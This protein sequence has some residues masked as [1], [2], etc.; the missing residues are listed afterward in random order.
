MRK[1][2]LLCVLGVGLAA[3]S[4]DTAAAAEVCAELQSHLMALEMADR[5]Q[6]EEQGSAGDPYAIERQRTVV[7]TALAA[8]RCRSAEAKRNNR[9]NRVF[10]GL[11]GNKRPF[12]SGLFREG[13]M[14]GDGFFGND[15]SMGSYRTLC[16]RTCDGYYFPISFSA[17]G[18]ELQRDGNACR[19]LCP[20]QD[21]A[22]YVQRNPGDEGGPMVSLAGE[23]YTALS[24]AFRYR[25]EYDRACT[26]G[27]IDG[28]TA[29]AFQAF[30]M[31]PPD[32][33]LAHPLEAAAAQIIPEPPARMREDDPDTTAN[34]AGGFVIRT[35]AR[36]PT[37]ETVYR[38]GPDGKVVRLV[39]PA[40]FFHGE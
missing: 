13:R 20:G 28:S 29:A 26:C 37:D 22:L 21:V 1:A 23:P 34:R 3:V 31:P 27:P 32:Q 39:G 36:Q 5:E 40:A 12:R 24:T 33:T 4:G 15:L 30:A 35:A 10:A 19:A 16:V 6:W 11:F 38:E 2:G 25:G 14:S 9:P 7:L 18:G 17:S 8:N